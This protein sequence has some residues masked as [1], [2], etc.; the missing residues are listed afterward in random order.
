MAQGYHYDSI[1]KIRWY[2][3]GDRCW[4]SS[5]NERWYRY[6]TTGMPH[7]EVP[8]YPYRDLSVA[9]TEIRIIVLTPDENPY[10]PIQCHLEQVPLGAATEYVALSYCWGG[11][12]R[13]IV[14]SG[15][16]LW[17]TENLA[18]ALQ[19]LRRRKIYRVWV[20]RICINQH[21][22]E[23]LAHQVEHM[24]DIY[25]YASITLAWL[26]YF[27]DSDTALFRRAYSLIQALM[28]GPKTK[29]DAHKD[30][31]QEPATGPKAKSSSPL[32]SQSHWLALS[33]MFQ[34]DY[35]S[36]VWI[37][38]EVAMSMRVEFFWNGQSISMSDLQRA[39]AGCKA[40]PPLSIK[41][42]SLIS[43]TVFE[44]VERLVRFRK[45]RE[46][47][48]PLIEAL[49]LSRTAKASN[50]RDKLYALKHLANDGPDS[51]PFPNY[52]ASVNNLNRT[53]ARRLLEHHK[54]ADY[55][56]LPC[57]SRETWVPEWHDPAT[58]GDERINNYLT[59]HSKFVAERTAR[60]A[61]S[62]KLVDKWRATRKSKAHW[63][64]IDD[65]R[66]LIVRYKRLGRVE[67]CSASDNEASKAEVG[68]LGDVS[69]YGPRK[70]ER[71][72]SLC[73]LLYDLIPN[74]NHPKPR[75]V[76]V[77]SIH[78]LLTESVRNS[79]RKSVPGFYKWLFC[80]RN[81][82]FKIDGIPLAN[83]LC[84][85]TIKTSVDTKK[86]AM[87]CYSNVQMGMRLFTT[88]RNHLGWATSSCQPGDELFLIQGCSVPVILRKQKKG[89]MYQLIG[90]SIVHGLMNGQGVTDGPFSDWPLLTLI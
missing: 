1:N 75:T 18:R 90:D 46:S 49:V 2:S 78:C 28:A 24:G 77:G 71:L 53:I 56:M 12:M 60:N 66:H 15:K 25:R 57:H 63:D 73:W 41:A 72:I 31:R 68:N 81:L 13:E 14:V 23:E 22:R 54:N 80:K 76:N 58:W 6:S 32:E 62:S 40:L 34:Q 33:S 35:W 83:W 29:N 84:A 19:E 87:Q 65:G 79:V 10:H 7:R 5:D 67:Q 89:D 52:K 50:P 51:V 88:D 44:H 61:G 85:A 64:T 21:N 30:K 11:E 36:R 69:K 8:D 17:V 9:K 82:K 42:N 86:K 38:Q 37:I 48:I 70:N 39:V 20:D 47:P 43:L 16:R 27:Q 4:Y 55:V 59:G 3:Y 26:G 45:F 74:N